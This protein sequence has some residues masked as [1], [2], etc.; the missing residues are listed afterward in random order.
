MPFD[1]IITARNTDIGAL[2]VQGQRTTERTLSHRCQR[3]LGFTLRFPSVLR[4]ARSG[5]PAAL[6][7]MNSRPTFHGISFATP[8]PSRSPRVRA[9][10]S[11]CRQSDRP[12][13][14]GRLRL[15][16]LKLPDETRSVTIPSNTLSSAKKA[17]SRVGSQRQ[18]RFNSGQD[19]PR[20]R[21]LVEIVFRNCIQRTPSLSDPSDS[22]VAGMPSA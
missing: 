19:R 11:R 1:G 10:R 6:T 3:T 21:Q 20:L 4:A 9:C 22:L 18:N 8:T 14:A 2:I 12:A 5:A 15:C 16:A 17:C 13:P 7:S